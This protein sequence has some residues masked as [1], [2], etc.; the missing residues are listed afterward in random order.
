MLYNNIIKKIFKFCFDIKITFAS[1]N[2][3]TLKEYLS[4]YIRNMFSCIFPN[5][6][7]YLLP[8]RNRQQ[9]ETFV[10]GNRKVEKRGKIFDNDRLFKKHEIST[11]SF[12]LFL[13]QC[14]FFS[15]DAALKMT[16]SHKFSKWRRTIQFTNTVLYHY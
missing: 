15:E 10:I 12:S 9:V 16:Y 2:K 1:S 11:K 13:V 14:C 7:W 3:Y 6:L 4:P 8:H 5:F